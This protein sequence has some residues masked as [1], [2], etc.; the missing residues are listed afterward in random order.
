[1][2][3]EL[4]PYESR[5]IIEYVN[6]FEKVLAC[7][8]MLT[9]WFEGNLDYTPNSS[10]ELSLMQY[11]NMLAYANTHYFRIG[12]HFKNNLKYI[13]ENYVDRNRSKYPNMVEYISTTGMV[14]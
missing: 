10:F 13:I 11:N 1:M 4:L 14:N 7:K 6:T 9:K 3:D 8:K 5:N 2:S 12:L